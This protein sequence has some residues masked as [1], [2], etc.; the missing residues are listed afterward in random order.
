MLPFSHF[1]RFTG[2]RQLSSGRKHTVVLLTNNNLRGFGH[3]SEGQL[4]YGSYTQYNNPINL[5][6]EDVGI[7]Q[8]ACGNYHTVVLMKDGTLY[9]FGA[10]G[11]GEL[12]DG[13]TTTHHRPIILFR[14]VAQ[15]DCGSNHT[16][17]LM[18]NGTI[19]RF[20][21]NEYGQLGDGSTTTRHIPINLFG[22]YVR[23]RQ[24]ACGAN[25]TILLMTDGT[26]RGFGA[27]SYGQL[28][29]GTNTQ[30]NTPVTLSWPEGNKVKQVA[31]G[32]YHTMVLMTDGTLH[33]FGRNDCGQLGDGTNTNRTTPFRVMENI[34]HVSCGYRH[35]MALMTNN[36]LCGFGRND[37]GQLGDG[38]TTNRNIPTCASEIKQFGLI[39]ELL[40]LYMIPVLANIVM[41]YIPIN[42]IV[43]GNFTMSMNCDS[44]LTAGKMSQ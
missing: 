9:G 18:T 27:N 39:A 38:T 10:N 1:K 41:E 5:F 8:V 17:A 13:S 2:V 42:L 25:H 12:G 3:N 43:A 28:G 22:E 37:C 14:G 4:G 34:T 24:V 30:R 35:T 16:V 20:G 15:V 7:R 36:N 44:I 31:C 19:R 40:D 33:G 21:Y 29:D 11:Y 6:G 23:V 32:Y 26:L